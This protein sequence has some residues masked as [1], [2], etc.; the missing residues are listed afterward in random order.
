MVDHMMKAAKLAAW[1]FWQ[2]FGDSAA[3][4]WICENELR[5]DVFAKTEAT[6]VEHVSYWTNWCPTEN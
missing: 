6:Y 5:E 1:S 4:G 2:P 3:Q